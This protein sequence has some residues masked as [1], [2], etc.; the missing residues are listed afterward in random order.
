MQKQHA[1]KDTA[2]HWL[3]ADYI[4]IGFWMAGWQIEILLKPK[5]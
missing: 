2:H 4:F 1:F 5:N 3:A